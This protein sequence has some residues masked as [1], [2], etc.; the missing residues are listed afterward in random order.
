MRV[1]CGRMRGEVSVI[2]RLVSFLFFCRFVGCGIGL[3]ARTGIGRLR[4]DNQSRNGVRDG[5]DAHPCAHTPGV[6]RTVGTQL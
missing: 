1:P 2:T 6:P 4:R 5:A 3:V